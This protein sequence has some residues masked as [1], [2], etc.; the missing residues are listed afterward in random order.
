MLRSPSKLKVLKICDKNALKTDDGEQYPILE[1][2]I[3]CLLNKKERDLI[4]NDDN[5]YDS[6]PFGKRDWSDVSDVNAGVE[7]ELKSLLRLY[8]KSSF[9]IDVGSGSGRISNYL[10]FNGYDNIVSLDYSLFSLKN[11]RKISNNVC[12]WAS[13]LCLPIASNSFDLLISSGVIHHTPDPYKSLKEC[14][15]VLK[16]GGRI[17]LRVYNRN[18]L[19]CYLYYTYGT[20][21][22]LFESMKTT[23][24]LS[25]IFGFGVYKF[26]RNMFYNLPKRKN[27]ILRAKYAN[28]FIKKMV[29]FFT[30]SEIGSL[31]KKDGLM[32]ESYKKIGLTHRMHCYVA[33]KQS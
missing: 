30:T 32:I 5:F 9:I 29:Y 11:V 16:P 7:N 14:I 2:G 33:K 12:I 20:L 17:Y 1:N 15:R 26:A 27:K 22:R 4:L 24:F 28:L 19:Y 21:L 8:A 13:N 23:K 31:L 10:Y 6:H 18:S 3:L 25:D